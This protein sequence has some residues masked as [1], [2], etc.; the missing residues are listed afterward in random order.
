M[1]HAKSRR[2]FVILAFLF[3]T[4]AFVAQEAKVKV[5]V[6][7]ALGVY[8]NGLASQSPMFFRAA[9]EN[10]PAPEAGTGASGGRLEI[11]GI[12]G[13]DSVYLNGKGPDFF[14]GTVK[15]TRT[16]NLVLPPGQQHVI[17]MDPKGDK[18]VYSGY[19][20]IKAGQKAVLHVDRS[21]TYYEKWSG[22]PATQITAGKATGTANSNNLVNTSFAPVTG[23]FSAPRWVD[24]GAKAPLVW[25]TNG[26]YSV[27]KA[28]NQIAQSGL[29]GSG[30][31]F[32]DPGEGTT[33]RIESFGPGGVFLSDP[34]TVGVKNDVTTTL[35][36]T[37]GSS[38]YRRVGD[39]VI[40]EPTITLEWTAKNANAVS[41][42][43]VPVSGTSGSKTV[44]F[45]PSNNEFGQRV[46]SR[47]YTIEATN[48]CGGK[49][50]AAAS[51]EVAE[52]IDPEI[53]AQVLPVEL[54][55]TGSPLPLI[56]LL[57]FGSMLSGV[58]LRKFRKG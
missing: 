41:I 8:N 45:T 19:V 35:T 32:V 47:V 2:Y 57:G 17:L 38:R 42:D 52:V 18:E 11:V 23:T 29:A 14:V 7:P 6:T 33:Y 44:K 34:Q 20:N 56:A 48:P 15:D 28:Y 4:C 39:K 3:V 22:G 13:S 58:A 12:K 21:D 54:P 49:S 31:L 1:S 26:A 43:G 30:Q 40:E 55:H 37:P 36:A 24:C 5:S 16:N 53:V 50:A 10:P 9:G 46:E 27:L 25:H 51:T